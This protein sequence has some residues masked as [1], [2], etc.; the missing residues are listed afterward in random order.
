MVRRFGVSG[1]ALLLALAV[2]SLAAADQRQ[3]RP[4]GPRAGRGD[5]GGS[6]AGRAERA[7]PRE[8]VFRERGDRSGRAD[9]R[10]DTRGRA[11]N[12]NRVDTR[13]RYDDRSR[14]DT[15]NRFDTRVDNR[16]RFDTRGG[17]S[18]VVPVRP[19]YRPDYGRGFRPAYRQIYRPVYQRPFYTFRPRLSLNVGFWA[20]VQVPFA[21][22]GIGLS[23][24]VRPF[25]T[26]R[27]RSYA[28]YVAAPYGYDPYAVQ[29]AYNTPYPVPAP[30]P[31]PY[32][33]PYPAAQ[34]PAATLPAQPVGAAT[35]LNAFGGL[36]FDIAPVDA[37]VYIDG[38]YA[39]TVAT[40][41]P[42]AQPLTLPV[43]VH[44][45]EIR[46]AGY[47]PLVFDA[48][49]TA[50]LVTPYQGTLTPQYD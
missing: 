27:Y 6:R 46:A 32:P 20:G 10:M 19:S 30:Y 29:P 18:R 33:V 5:D 15:R 37:A 2:P 3:R 48:T 1:L 23:V 47:Q 26:A 25:L 12:R 11:D 45:I 14:F 24:P 4:D 17:R 43:G 21:S 16:N 35:A 44:R 39:G 28:P 8:S 31:A 41:S 40:F 50:G 38:E 42:E 9:T 7:I 13:N 22:F 49:V 36:S 34:S